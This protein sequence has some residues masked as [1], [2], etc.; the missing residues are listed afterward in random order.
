MG[1]RSGGLRTGQSAGAIQFREADLST[2]A[3]A[4]RS[5]LHFSAPPNNGQIVTVKS[6]ADLRQI[7]TPQVLLDLVDDAGGGYWMK[8]Y[9]PAQG[10]VE[11]IDL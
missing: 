2:N 7:M 9:E 4:S 5:R 6:G 10:S 8:F 1:S 11:W 3:P